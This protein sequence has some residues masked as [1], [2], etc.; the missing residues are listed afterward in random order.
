MIGSRV[1][2]YA[3]LDSSALVKFLVAEAETAALEHD[4]V[5]R[6]G[7]LSSR[8]A[9]TELQRAVRRARQRRLLQQLED[10][11]ASVV[12]IELSPAILDRA[13]HLSP[14]ALRTLDAIHLATILSLNL[15][16]CDFITYDDR[17]AGAARDAGL[18]VR[19]PR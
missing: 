9:A 6:Q 15:T 2:P 13:G 7:L 4:A 3:Y 8:L 14:P 12:L 5:N 10:V 18:T 17:L 19:Q 16:A 11:L 1:S